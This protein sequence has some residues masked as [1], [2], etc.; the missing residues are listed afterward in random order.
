MKNN[1]L[2]SK[3]NEIYLSTNKLNSK[4]KNMNKLTSYNV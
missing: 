2:I 4:S 1:I 3:T